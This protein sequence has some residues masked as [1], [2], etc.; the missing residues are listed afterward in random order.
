[1]CPIHRILVVD[2]CPDTV[3]ST[4]WLLRLWGHEVQSAHDGPA[5]LEAARSYRPDVVLTEIALP[6]MDGCDLARR[7]RDPGALPGA[8]PV[9]V[10]GYATE[11]YRRRCREAGFDYLLIKP[12][13]PA[14][15]EALPR[16]WTHRLP[17]RE[18]AAPP[19]RTVDALA[20]T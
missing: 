2:P 19:S 8:L 15:L 11:P 17:R 13:E 9:A 18:T 1:M 12:G 7:L 6:W 3:A 4:A 5:A 16:R 14:V 10:T 20:V